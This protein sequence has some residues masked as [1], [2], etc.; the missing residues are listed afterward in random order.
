VPSSVD[1]GQLFAA[2]DL[3]NVNWV[4]SETSGIGFTP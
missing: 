2:L 4:T 3:P 1:T